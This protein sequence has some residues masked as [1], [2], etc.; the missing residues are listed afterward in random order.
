MSTAHPRQAPGRAIGVTP[1]AALVDPSRGRPLRIG[2]L[3][4][5]VNPRGGVVHTL[6]L[7]DALRARGHEVTV[8]APARGGERLFRATRAQVSLAPLE[9]GRRPA[10]TGSPMEA[11]SALHPLV[12]SVGTR[13]DAMAS[14]LR[15]HPGLTGFDLLHSQ[16]SITA[17]ALATLRDEGRIAGF[18]RTVHHLD[19]F[20]QATLAAWQRRGVMA[21]SQLLCVSPLWQ[22]I[23]R[24]GWGRSAEVVPNGVDTVRFNAMAQ[25]GDEALLRGLGV[26]PE[27]PV[28][29][30]VGGVEERKNSL[31]LLE[32]FALARTQ[33]PEAQLV[34]AGG[35]SLLDH[36]DT[37]RA[38][39]TALRRHGFH[40]HRAHPE[41]LVTGPLP[42]AALPAL[43]RRA[44]ALAMPSLREGFGLAALEALAC[45][46]P[47]IVSRIAPFVDH[48]APH[49]VL[50]AD[51]LDTQ[52]L[53]HALQRSLRPADTAPV[54][55]AAAAVCRRFSWDRSAALHEAVYRAVL[56]LAVL[57]DAPFWPLS[58]PSPHPSDRHA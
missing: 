29:L 15:E 11:P 24:D 53:A 7:A 56:S 27:G 55:A 43:Y 3:T 8:F 13:I 47:A 5:S 35:A 14:H 17:N 19:E 4:H 58:H 49:E 21:A 16:D 36:D 23:L 20:E 32:A 25:H 18:V 52:D 48:F 40:Q 2:L 34:I 42:D 54:R 1:R 51:P 33:T 6:E 12:A 30:A 50:W 9:E 57:Q 10:D 38:F 26:Q 31:R 37:Q 41:V 39:S 22:Q 44:T 45:G 46:T 28:W